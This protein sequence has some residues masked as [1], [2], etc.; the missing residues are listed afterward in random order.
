M[1]LSTSQGKTWQSRRRWILPVAFV[2]TLLFISGLVF[3]HIEEAEIELD[4][5]VTGVGFSLAGDQVLGGPLNAS[6][7]GISG[8]QHMIMPVAMVRG[9]HRDDTQNN[10]P[11]ALRI[12]Q[13]DADSTQAKDYIELFVGSR[14]S[15]GQCAP[16]RDE[17]G[18]YPFVGGF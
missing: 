3:F 5:S 13:P 10:Q 14:Q 17:I 15:T 11:M 7:L 16:W 9:D 4:L 12:F 6:T 2:V 1:Q 18:V 8:F